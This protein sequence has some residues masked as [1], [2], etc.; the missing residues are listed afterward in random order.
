MSN[1]NRPVKQV[2]IAGGGT[3]GWIVAAALSQQFGDLLTITLVESEE[4]GTVGVGE[5]SIPPMKSFHNFLQ[6]NEQEF[7]RATEATFKLAIAF[8]NWSQQGSRYLHA[9]GKVGQE[10]MLC[11]F[12]HFWM[13]GLELGVSAELGTYCAEHQAAM[14]NKFAVSPQ[15]NLNYAYHLDATLYAKFLR[16]FAEMRG[17]KRVEG[18]IT[19]VTQH[20]ESG[21]IESLTMESGQIVEGDL[22]VDCTGFRG[23]L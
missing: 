4:I 9:F 16:K 11:E 10:T 7:M 12:H 3:A 20:P 2:V 22:F 15:L 14:A 8:E 5:A 13:R 17:T 21:F 19:A 6:I 1:T 23:L 18:K